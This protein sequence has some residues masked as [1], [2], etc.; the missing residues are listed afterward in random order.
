[1]DDGELPRYLSE[2]EDFLVIILLSAY[3][4]QFIVQLLQIFVLQEFSISTFV[5]YLSF[6]QVVD[7]TLQI[8]DVREL[9]TEWLYLTLLLFVNWF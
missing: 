2:T 1:M 7:L 9:D 8:I 4:Y 5:D 6:H 3:Q